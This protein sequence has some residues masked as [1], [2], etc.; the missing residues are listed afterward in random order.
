MEQARRAHAEACSPATRSTPKTRLGALVSEQQRENVLGYVESGRREG[1]KLVAGG[2]GRRRRRQG[3]YFM[4]PT[5]FD[6]V[7]DRR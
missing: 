1:A 5:V 6:G 7:D 4:K 3:R 2:D